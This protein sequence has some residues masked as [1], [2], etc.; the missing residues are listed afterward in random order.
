[1]KSLVDSEPAIADA[2]VM[3]WIESSAAALGLT[4]Q[5]MPSGAVTMRRRWRRL[6]RWA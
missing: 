4:R 5:R 1:M 3:G 6:R 2:Q